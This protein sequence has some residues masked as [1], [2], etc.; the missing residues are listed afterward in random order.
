MARGPRERLIGLFDYVEQVVRLDE[1]VA[2]R[3]S[4][5]RLADGTSFAIRPSDTANLP[6]IQ[7]DMQEEEGPVWLAVARLPRREPPTPPPELALTLPETEHSRT[8]RPFELSNA[9][10]TVV[11]TSRPSFL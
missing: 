6:G 8:A 3:V 11:A 1:S 10:R 5:Y 7:L 9:S 2:F 4:D